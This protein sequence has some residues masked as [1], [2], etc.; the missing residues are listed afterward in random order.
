MLVGATLPGTHRPT[1]AARGRGQTRAV[2]ATEFIK[3]WRKVQLT[4]RSASHEHFFDLCAVLDH[5]TPAE[6]DP[7]GWTFTFEK[8]VRKRGGSACAVG[9]SGHMRNE[10]RTAGRSR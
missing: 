5:P 10:V 1:V 6:A 3:K 4:E 9:Q 2:N 8:G 7:E